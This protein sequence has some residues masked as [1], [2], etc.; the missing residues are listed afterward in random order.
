[1]RE[2]AAFAIRAEDGSLRV[3]LIN[4]DF[5][6]G[7]RVRI[8]PGRSFGVASITRLVGPAADATAG[9]TLGGARVDDFGHWAPAPG[10][11]A[12]VAAREVA[13][14]VPAASAALVTLRS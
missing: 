7:A 9:I 4:R 8:D 6:R 13:V 10:E 1:M 12:H 5:T 14:D 2:L 3:C 11:T